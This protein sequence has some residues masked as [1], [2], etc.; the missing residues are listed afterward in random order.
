MPPHLSHCRKFLNPPPPSPFKIKV[1]RLAASIF[2][3]R[4]EGILLFVSQIVD[5]QPHLQIHQQ[6]VG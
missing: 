5:I 6:Y 3:L 1:N 2:G 4:C